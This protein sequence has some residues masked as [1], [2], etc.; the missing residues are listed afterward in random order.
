MDA[1]S[2]AIAR[3][4]APL[5]T[6]PAVGIL[7]G[8][9]VVLAA[10]FFVMGSRRLRHTPERTLDRRQEG[11]TAELALGA[12]ERMGPLGRRLYLVQEVT[13]DLLFPAA[14]ALWLAAL[15]GMALGYLHPR[16]WWPWLACAV[17]VL[18]AVFDYLENAL[19][20]T[21]LLGVGRGSR[22]AG[23]ARAAAFATRAKWRLCYASL[24]ISAALW[25]GVLVDWMRDIR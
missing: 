2:D 12:L 20:V 13:L 9:L 15:T 8:V 7:T 16:G 6:A 21:L 10:A 14:Y 5:A 1:L 11:Y 25:G 23:A 18:A 19:V 22:P 3:W 24:A 17:P 4:I